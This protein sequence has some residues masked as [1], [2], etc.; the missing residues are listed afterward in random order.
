MAEARRV[1]DH[2]AQQAEAAE[3]MAVQM[4][5]TDRLARLTQAAVEAAVVQFH[6]V[7]AQAVLVVQVL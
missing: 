1:L 4:K 3:A 5:I 7:L 2:L 6:Q